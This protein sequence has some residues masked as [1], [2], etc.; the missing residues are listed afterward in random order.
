MQFN[1]RSISEPI[2]QGNLQVE[3][4]KMETL[5]EINL[6]SYKVLDIKYAPN[7]RLYLRHAVPQRDL[8]IL[9]FP[10]YTS[11]HIANENNKISSRLEDNGV[12]Y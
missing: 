4:K 2:Q 10:R 8:L 3:L 7:R 9:L 5:L 11:H 12:F 6:T 1:S